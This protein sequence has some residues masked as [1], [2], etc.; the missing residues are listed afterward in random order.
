MNVFHK[1][2]KFLQFAQWV[3]E[4]LFV[5][6]FKRFLRVFLHRSLESSCFCLPNPPANIRSNQQ[7]LKS[8][9]LCIQKTSSTSY[10]IY[11]QYPLQQ[12]LSSIPPLHE[13]APLHPIYHEILSRQNMYHQD[14]ETF[15]TVQILVLLQFYLIVLF[16][17]VITQFSI[18]CH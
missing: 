3:T 10:N 7:K 1:V 12:Y 17:K 11:H 6:D 13:Y 9:R 16:H 8:S 4:I 2:L 18:Y 14:T 5:H 15:Y